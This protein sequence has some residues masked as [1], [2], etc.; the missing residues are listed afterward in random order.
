MKWESCFWE[1]FG[2]PWEM[3]EKVLSCNSLERLGDSTGCFKCQS[4]TMG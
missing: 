4:L 1:G 3:K 2:F